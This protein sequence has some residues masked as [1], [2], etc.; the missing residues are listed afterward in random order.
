M[1]KTITTVFTLLLICASFSVSAQLNLPS[2]SQKASATQRVGTTDITITYSRPSVRGR[3][4]WGKLVPFGL[5]NLGFGTSKAAPWRAGADENTTITFEHDVKVQGQSVAAGTYGLH[6]NVKDANSAALILSKDKDAW[7]SYF[8]DPANDVLNTDITV[9]DIPH[10]ETLTYAFDV[11]TPTSTTASLKWEK[12]AFDFKIEV[13]VADIV[14]NDIR[15]QFKGQKGFTRQNWEQAANF[16]MNNG[17]DLDE[18]LGWINNALEGQFFSQKT[19]NGLAIKAQI[20]QKKGDSEGFGTTM[21]EALTLATP[22]Q[23]NRMGYAMINAKDYNR[24]IKY[25]NTNLAKDS[26]NANWHSSLAD[27]YKAKGDKKMAAKHYKKALSLNPNAR[28]KASAEK[29]LKEVTS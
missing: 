13:D 1:K 2:G 7:G 15:S 21:D 10:E 3:E 20:L 26:K 12:K 9:K 22:A 6:L 11:V 19:V 29:G 27:G 5:N 28:V 18:A 14:M 25:F 4:V 23:V 17:G 8:Y 24:A 16:A